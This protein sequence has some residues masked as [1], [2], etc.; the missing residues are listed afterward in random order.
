MSEN[1]GLRLAAPAPAPGPIAEL[2][3]EREARTALLSCAGLYVAGGTLTA[4]SALLPKVS[5]PAGV[6]AVAL[7]AYA[8]AAG[9]VAA[10]GRER[11]RLQIA[12][13]ADLWGVVLIAVLCASSG[14]ASSPFGLIYFFA[15]GHAAAFQSRTRVL[16]VC[17]AALAGFLAPVAYGHV[18]RSYW[19]FACVGAVLAMLCAAVVHIAL[20]RMRDQRWR[21][22]FLINATANLDTALDP[23]QNLQRVA[24][25]AVPELADLCVVD[26]IDAEGTI[27]H[28]ITASSDPRVAAAMQRVRREHPLGIRGA[29]PVARALRAWEPFVIHDLHES[30]GLARMAEGGSDE[31][32]RFLRDAGIH[33]AA[34]LPMV[35]RGRMLGAISFLRLS[36]E[37][38]YQQG[39]LALLEDLTGRAALAFDNARLYAERAQVA[40][41]LRRSLMPSQLP[42]VAG[43]EL[44]SF[45]QPMGA[46]NEVGG[47]FYDVFIDGETCWLVV[48][49]V[50]GKGAEAAVMTGFLRH[51]AMAYAREGVAPSTVL[52]RV[53]EAML[54]QDF[55]GRFA[56]AVLARMRFGENGVRLTV[57]TAGHPP[58]LITRA[59]G[60]AEE[61]GAPGTLLGVFA[62][63]S[64]IDSD[65]L[66]RAGDS[67]SLYTDGLSEAHAPERLISVTEMLRALD[68]ERPRLA[69]EAI[70]VLLA[71][72]DLRD[73]PPRDDIAV[74]AARVQGGLRPAA[75]SPAAPAAVQAGLRR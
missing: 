61:F 60:K 74:L 24:D 31:Q 26:L 50:C 4:T 72:A 40:H 71:L 65:T 38:R 39:K 32:A 63:P 22:E 57:A 36:G 55:E 62:D 34:V 6:I 2:A 37:G 14:G 66:L 42:A 69:Q 23:H 59:A 16:V 10:R 30:A 48:G 67:L 21:L 9:L 51:T 27:T 43:L 28:T 3:S 41:T 52:E 25:T 20:Q 46:G 1:G 13:I 5:S 7:V 15:I 70:D 75:A 12:W 73:A 54:D 11:S 29:H 56:T 33:S 68:S 45:F 49:D 17:A 64:I 47:D 35:A 44:A 19:A 58:A 18:M 53:N 8:T